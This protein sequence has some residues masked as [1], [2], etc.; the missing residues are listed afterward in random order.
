M[1]LLLSYAAA[2]N[3]L[4]VLRWDLKKFTRRT[5]CTVRAEGPGWDAGSTLEYEQYIVPDTSLVTLE[6]PVI[7]VGRVSA[8]VSGLSRCIKLFSFFPVDGVP[9]N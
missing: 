9:A 2:K 3:S 1:R 7:S 5:R 4:D 6:G 8:S